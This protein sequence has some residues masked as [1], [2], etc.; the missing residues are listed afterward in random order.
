MNVARIA[1]CHACLDRLW[2]CHFY[3][4]YN[5]LS[6]LIVVVDGIRKHPSTHTIKTCKK[7]HTL[8]NTLEMEGVHTVP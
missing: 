2:T 6:S 4:A 1:A 5:M 3:S 8:E 7:T